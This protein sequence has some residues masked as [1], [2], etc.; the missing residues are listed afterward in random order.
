MMQ[1]HLVYWVLELG[2]LYYFY[3]YG[4]AGF[5]VLALVHCAAVSL[6]DV[7]VHCVG[8]VLYRFYHG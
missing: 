7:R 3:A 8:V 5:G 6:A 2:H 1:K 4:L